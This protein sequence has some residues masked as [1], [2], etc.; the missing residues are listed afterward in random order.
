M[1]L[2]IAQNDEN[3]GAVGVRCVSL[4]HL[5]PIF[6]TVNRPMTMPAF[7]KVHLLGKNGWRA[8]IGPVN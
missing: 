8:L 4:A 6:G 7:T 2:R 5:A 3:Y 1:I